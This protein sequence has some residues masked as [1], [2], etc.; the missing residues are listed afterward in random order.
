[1]Y[2]QMSDGFKTLDMRVILPI[3]LGG[4]VTLALFSK[5]VHYIFK[6]AYPQLFHFIFGIVLAST[7][8]IIPT[9]YAGFD[10]VQYLAC[11]VMLGFGTWLGAFMAK[12]EDTYK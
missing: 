2:N 11:V 10:I 5:L 9:N 8:M 1:M 12:L 3:A 7:V 6:K 4:L